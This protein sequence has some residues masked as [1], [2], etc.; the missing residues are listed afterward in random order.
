MAS[1]DQNS[2]QPQKLDVG[3]VAVTTILFTHMTVRKLWK[4]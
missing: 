2:M 4:L 3:D 1:I